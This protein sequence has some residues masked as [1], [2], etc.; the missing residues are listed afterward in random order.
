MNLDELRVLP[1]SDDIDIYFIIVDGKGRTA[2][3]HTFNTEN[4]ARRYINDLKNSKV[5][6]NAKTSNETT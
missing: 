4:E 3:H 1:D 6:H 2:L 5:K